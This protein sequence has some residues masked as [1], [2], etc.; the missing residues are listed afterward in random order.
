MFLALGTLEL[1]SNRFNMIQGDIFVFLEIYRTND[2]LGPSH[3]AVKE[4]KIKV[5]CPL[6]KESTFVRLTGLIA[7]NFHSQCVFSNVTSQC[8]RSLVLTLSVTRRD[9]IS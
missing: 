8:S 4:D 9:A 5:D 6:A 1:L 7:F 2:L 3:L